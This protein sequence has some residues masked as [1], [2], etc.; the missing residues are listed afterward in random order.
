MPITCEL[1]MV[2]HGEAVCNVRGVLG[3]A[4]GCTGL[5]ADGRAQASRLAGRLADEHARKPFDAFYAT[6][7]LR[8][9]QPA[10]SETSTSMGR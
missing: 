7:R 9:R 4:L 8:V 3:G 5:T 1:V 10:G 6:P 2:R